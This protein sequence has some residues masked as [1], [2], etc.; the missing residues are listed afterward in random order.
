MDTKYDLE[1]FENTCDAIQEI[2]D[3]SPEAKDAL[4]RV[5]AQALHELGRQSIAEIIMK[6][7]IS[8][9]CQ[10]LIAAEI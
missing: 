2:S 10:E 6:D 7:L 8:D 4:L 9:T 5:A 3:T 1:L